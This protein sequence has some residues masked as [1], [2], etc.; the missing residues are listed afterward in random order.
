MVR[1]TFV[2]NLRKIGEIPVPEGHL[3]RNKGQS[4]FFFSVE[5]RETVQNFL[6]EH[7]G[8]PTPIDKPYPS[9]TLSYMV[10]SKSV[11]KWVDRSVLL[12]P[13]TEKENFLVVSVAKWNC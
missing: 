7:L 5:Q 8:E 10:F 11:P 4:H 1:A 13:E 2:R 9:G 12:W 6:K 3:Q